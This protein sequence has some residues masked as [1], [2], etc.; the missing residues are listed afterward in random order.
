MPKVLP[1]IKRHGY[2]PYVQFTGR[3]A[4]PLVF[5]KRGGDSSELESKINKPGGKRNS[6]S[7]LAIVLKEDYK[8]T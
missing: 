2:L 7:R 6:S 4:L 8:K 1:E 3:A 5:Y